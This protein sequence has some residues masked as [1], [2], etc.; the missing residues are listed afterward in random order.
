M[1]RIL[2]DTCVWLD[3]AKDHQQA[4][5]LD[6]LEERL[7]SGEVE[8]ILPRIVVDEFVRNKA[9]VVD[10]ARRS[11]SSALRR[12]KALVDQLGEGR[13]RRQ[14]I[15]HLEEL[16]FRLPTLGEAAVTAVGRIEAIFSR[17]QVI[18]NDDTLLV[19]AARRGVLKRAPFHRN[20][21][22]VSDAVLLEISM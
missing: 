4:V 15:A 8:L 21:N 22:S 2:V 7:A 3:L 11:Q 17:S 9:R 1:F 19:L 14:A 6:V 13:G 20:H 12:A 18:E 10:E 16:D 5:L